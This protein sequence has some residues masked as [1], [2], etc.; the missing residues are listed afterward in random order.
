MKQLKVEDFPG[1]TVVKNL[2]ANL[3]D[4]GLIPVSGRSP[5]EENGNLLQF[6]CWE[7]PWTEE[8]GRLPS[9]WSARVGHHLATKATKTMTDWSTKGLSNQFK[10][11]AGGAS[12]KV[13]FQDPL[14]FPAYTRYSTGKSEAMNIA[15][16]KYF[17]SSHAQNINIH[18]IL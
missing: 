18:Y 1:G 15:L 10:L 17:S 14:C 8:P 2:P 4:S 16:A 3:G 6:S 9:M 13:H 12:F 11:V 5:E 7:T